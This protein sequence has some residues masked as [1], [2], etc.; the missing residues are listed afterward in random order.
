MDRPTPNWNSEYEASRNVPST[1][2]L[3]K[4]KSGSERGSHLCRLHSKVGQKGED[5]PT[6]QA[7]HLVNVLPPRLSASAWP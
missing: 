1:F 3:D 7:K 5:P 4:L 2:M 6:L